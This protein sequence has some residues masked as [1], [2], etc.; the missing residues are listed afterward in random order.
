MGIKRGTRRGC[1]EITG[2]IQLWEAD[3]PSAVAL[4]TH[5]Q[6]HLEEVPSEFS[7]S[8]EPKLTRDVEHLADKHVGPHAIRVGTRLVEGG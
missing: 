2:A 6:D 5:R 3:A 7:D 8:G 1:S 4:L